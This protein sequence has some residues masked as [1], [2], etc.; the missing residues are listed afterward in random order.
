MGPRHEHLAS[1]LWAITAY[2][3]PARYQRRRRNFDIFRRNLEIPLVAVELAFGAAFELE[4]GDAEILVQVRGGDVLW[5][6]E[7]LLSIAFRHVP[8]ECPNIVWMDCD[9]ILHTPSF[10]EQVVATLEKYVLVQPFHQVRHLAK[11]GSDGARPEA[12]PPGFTELGLAH[13]VETSGN[14]AENLT[15]AHAVS[16]GMVWAARRELLERHDFYDVCVVGGGPLAMA[17]AAYGQFD[18]VMDHMQMNEGQRS[19]FLAWAESYFLS[20]RGNVGC[21]PATISHLWHGARDDRGYRTRYTGLRPYAF[22]PVC[23]LSLTTE[24]VWQWGSA[25]P[26]LHEYVKRY[27]LSRRED[28]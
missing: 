20:V 12:N 5:Q 24:N 14:L 15:A 19:H 22:D 9:T 21:I 4:P 8:K 16:K 23:D 18:L 7:R 3:N 2:F 26:S 11:N 28:G 1:P 25:K 27:F 6:K 17:A 13:A 10:V